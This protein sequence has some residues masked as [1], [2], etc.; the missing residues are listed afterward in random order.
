MFG[1][2]VEVSLHLLIEIALWWP[3]FFGVV[4]LLTC[5][6]FM[7]L[8]HKEKWYMNVNLFC[9]PFWILLLV[10]RNPCFFL[11]KDKK[12]MFVKSFLVKP[13]AFP[14]KTKWYTYLLTHVVSVLH[15]D[16]AY[17]ELIVQKPK[18]YLAYGLDATVTHSFNVQKNKFDEK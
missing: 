18:Q 13:I 7:P 8:F 12:K 9:L 16:D 15:I 4:K 6:G 5:H 14:D 1:E 2:A 3:L 17:L 10:D 11:K